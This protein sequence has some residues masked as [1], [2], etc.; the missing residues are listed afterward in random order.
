[1]VVL[2]V[3][4]VMADKSERANTGYRNG[5]FSVR[6]IASWCTMAGLFHKGLR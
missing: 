2:R 1:M 3:E 5:L 4:K 6:W